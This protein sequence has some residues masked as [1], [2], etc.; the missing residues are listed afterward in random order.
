MSQRNARV[1]W[2]VMLAIVVTVGSV[3]ADDD[4]S[5]FASDPV[6]PVANIAPVSAMLALGSVNIENIL[7]LDKLFWVKG[8]LA[9]GIDVQSPDPSDTRVWRKLY[10]NPNGAIKANPG[11]QGSW[12]NTLIFPRG[13]FIKS[14]QGVLTLARFSVRGDNVGGLI[15]GNGLPKDQGQRRI[16]LWLRQSELYLRYT[17]WEVNADDFADDFPIADLDVN[18]LDKNVVVGIWVE[19]DGQSVRVVLPSGEMTPTYTLKSSIFGPTGN[20]VVYPVIF[21]GYEMDVILERIIFTYPKESP[22]ARP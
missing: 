2:S 14:D 19:P 11:P 7:N 20:P 22:I 16:F 10:G 4:T 3:F 6:S 21:A 15:L 1:F 12:D 18:P 13:T 9:W 8:P 5:T 17:D